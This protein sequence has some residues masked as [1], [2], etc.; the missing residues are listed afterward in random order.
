MTHRRTVVGA[1]LAPLLLAAPHVSD[2]R[3]APEVGER[4]EWRWSVVTELELEE[5]LLTLDGT[6]PPFGGLLD[7][8]TLEVREELELVAVDHLVARDEEAPRELERRFVRAQQE[9]CVTS[10]G[11][12]GFSA[13]ED[14]IQ[15]VSRF[16]GAQVTF[17]R[18]PK[19][20]RID[21][22]DAELA[23]PRE[24]VTGRLLDGLEER[25]DLRGLLDG[26]ERSVG[27]TWYVSTAA[28]RELLRP[29]GD[30]ALVAPESDFEDKHEAATL[31]W[32]VGAG[33]V[34]GDFEDWGK[35]RYEGI[36]LE[37]GRE[38]ACL[39]I[40]FEVEVGGE[41]RER[42]AE[43]METLG[44]GRTWLD[45]TQEIH[46][47]IDL[48]LEGVLLWD[49]AAGRAWSLELEGRSEARLEL[50]LDVDVFFGQGEWRL[51]AELSGTTRVD[52]S[53]VRAEEDED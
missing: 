19:T 37:E 42:L 17:L 15:T 26:S 9:T 29:G 18:D 3:W 32:L 16:E 14:R 13:D 36:V 31:G 44:S 8:V 50:L 22:E 47:A 45:L 48:D 20:G 5:L 21:A 1:A 4:I 2:V 33:L 39:R 23:D 11:F 27:E 12:W 7:D 24:R 25:I 30:L 35:V 41:V 49:L 52:V 34:A 40:D 46:V 53:A 28:V 43:L 6:N 10:D 38:L 51:V